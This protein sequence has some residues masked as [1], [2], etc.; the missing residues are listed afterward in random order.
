MNVLF[1]SSLAAIE[2]EAFRETFNE[3]AVFD[4]DVTVESDD[5]DA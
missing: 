3:V 1:P 2:I 4:V 5:D